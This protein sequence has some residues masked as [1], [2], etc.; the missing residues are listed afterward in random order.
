MKLGLIGDKGK[1]NSNDIVWIKETSYNIEKFNLY[2]FH[3]EFLIIL[4]CNPKYT[5]KKKLRM[6]KLFA[7]SE[8]NYVK[9]YRSL[10]HIESLFFQLINLL[11]GNDEV[12][13]DKEE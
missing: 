7:E 8:H 13:N 2:K 3:K 12:D 11:V 9:S 4:L 10:I 5:Y 1:I 6:T